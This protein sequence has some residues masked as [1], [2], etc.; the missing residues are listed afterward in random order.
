GFYFGGAF[1]QA[2]EVVGYF[3]LFD[4]AL[5]ALLDQIG[6]FAPSEMAEHHDAREDHRAGIDDVFVGVLGGGAV[7][8][9]EDG[10][11]VAD[12]RTGSDAEAADLRSAGIGNVVAVQ[13]GRGENAVFV[14]P[15]HNLL[16]DRVGDAVVDHQLFLP[17]ALAMRGIDRIETVFYFFVEI[18]A[19]I[20]G[21]E[22]ETGLDEV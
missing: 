11:A 2:L 1:H 18:T 14:G 10:V 3:F 21:G 8:R 9:F 16:E 13:V 22:L 12:V 17:R 19:K 4:G 5:Q 20:V 15:G 6:G 7:R